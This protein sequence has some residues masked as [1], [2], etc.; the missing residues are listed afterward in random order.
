MTATGIINKTSMEMLRD[1]S[2]RLETEGASLGHCK[3]H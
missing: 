1:T 3:C 2:R